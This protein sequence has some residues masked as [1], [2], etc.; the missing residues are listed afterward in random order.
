MSSFALCEE[1]CRRIHFFEGCED[2]VS[3]L[4][5]EKRYI[6]QKNAGS[7]SSPEDRLKSFA[8][9]PEAKV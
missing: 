4:E 7:T 8:I 5:S 6:V 2:R 3:Y 1:G 9:W